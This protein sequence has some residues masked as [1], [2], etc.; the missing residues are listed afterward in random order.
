M[1]TYIGTKIVKL[2]PMTRADYNN[3]RGWQLPA[4]ENGADEGYL[5]EYADGGKPND[6]RHEGYISWS[7][8]AQADAAY[9]PADGLPFG[10]AIEAAKLGK[11]IARAPAGTAKACSSSTCRAC[12]SR[13]TER[14][15]QSER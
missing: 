9:R 2:S 12:S 14:R 5:V 7:P 4:D 6:A 1:Q 15:A 10:L 11:R 8:K 3:Y 13:P